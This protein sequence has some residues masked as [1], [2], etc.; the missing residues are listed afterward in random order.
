M[1]KINRTQAAYFPPQL[2]NNLEVIQ[3]IYV[4]DIFNPKITVLQSPLMFLRHT[5]FIIHVK[6]PARLC[7][8]SF[9]TKSTLATWNFRTGPWT[10]KIWILVNTGTAALLIVPHTFAAPICDQSVLWHL[11]KLEVEI[12]L[13]RPQSTLQSAPKRTCSPEISDAPKDAWQRF[14]NEWRRASPNK[15]WSRLNLRSARSCQNVDSYKR[16]NCKKNTSNVVESCASLQEP[17]NPL[18]T[19]STCE[20]FYQIGPFPCLGP[21]KKPSSLTSRLVWLLSR[22][23]VKDPRKH[24]SNH[25]HIAFCPVLE[26]FLAFSGLLQYSRRELRKTLHA[27]SS[28]ILSQNLLTSPYIVWGGRASGPIIE[29]KYCSWNKVQENGQTF[30]MRQP[31]SA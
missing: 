29:K 10:F 19:A 9:K 28:K 31:T 21:V 25:V 3:C 13:F 12:F 26:H 15:A 22:F 8:G 2:K 7:F 18:F 16:K 4:D 6:E 11:Q 14:R 30:P 17:C 5:A 20:P 23:V 1:T 27:I 24:V